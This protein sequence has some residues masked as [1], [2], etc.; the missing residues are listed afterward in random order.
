MNQDIKSIPIT[1]LKEEVKKRN[2]QIFPK[3]ILHYCAP[4]V[5]GWG[6]VRVACLVP[7]AIVLF[8]IPP[9][10]GRH[11]AIASFMHEYDNQLYYLYMSEVDIVTGEHMNRIEGAIDE[12]LT[13]IEKKPKAIVLCSTC[14]DDL[15]GSDYI[16]MAEQL[17]SK[18]KLDV[19]IGKMNPIRKESKRP[20]ELLI[21]KTIYDFLKPSD[22][23]ENTINIIGS[24]A[25]ISE[26]CEIH[27]L[28]KE[29]GIEQLIHIRDCDT[30]EAFQ[31]MSQSKYN[32]LIKPGGKI[33][34]LEMEKTLGIPFAELPVS[35]RI[36]GIEENYKLMEQHLNMDLNY[37]MHKERC[38]YAVKGYMNKLKGASIAVG[39]TA[40]VCAFEAAREFVERGFYVPFVFADQLL[41][42]DIQHVEWLEE[43]ADYI[44]VYSTTNPSMSKFLLEDKRVDLAIGFDAGY[45]CSGSKTVPLSV[46]EQLYGFKGVET[47]YARMAETIEGQQDFRMEMYHSGM[48]I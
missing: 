17:R 35:Y 15:L 26:D 18:F 30:Y 47:L 20:P 36:E 9:G 21:Q 4:S 43:N 44:K 32:F 2:N 40:N 14:T 7:E 12:I 28:F 38:E 13:R 37:Q 45:F 16:G 34:A 24:F 8:V 11:G 48:V 22:K 25:N 23:K 1:T 42:Y 31:K 19:Q 3:N 27:D 5:G 29:A 41:P 6:V 46:D 10:C 39:A 33:A